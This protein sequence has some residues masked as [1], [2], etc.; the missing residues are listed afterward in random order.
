MAAIWKIVYVLT[1]TI[2]IIEAL[3]TIQ[4]SIESSKELSHEKLDKKSLIA[5][6]IKTMLKKFNQINE[7]YEMNR[8]TKRRRY[9]DSENSLEKPRR[10]TRKV[11]NNRFRQ[12]IDHHIVDDQ[13]I[14]HVQPIKRINLHKTHKKRIVRKNRINLM[15]KMK[16]DQRKLARWIKSNQNNEIKIVQTENHSHRSRRSLDLTREQTKKLNTLMETKNEDD[17]DYGNDDDEN[18]EFGK[19]TERNFGDYELDTTDTDQFN[20]DNELLQRYF[21]SKQRY[22]DDY[23]TFADVIHQVAEREEN[24]NRHARQIFS[25]DESSEESYEDYGN[26]GGHDSEY[27]EY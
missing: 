11:S 19:R 6:P 8:P 9:R 17:Y 20:E 14:I 15:K 12:N 2:I 26:L 7:M 13:Q 3:P 18:K 21:N 27:V 25:N 24:E 1:V 22:T 10:S 16:N 5:T 23:D 4:K